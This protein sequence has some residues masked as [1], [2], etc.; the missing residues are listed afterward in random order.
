MKKLIHTF[1]ILAYKESPFLEECILSVLNQTVIDNVVIATSTPN[2]YIKTLARKYNLEIIVNYNG[3]EG[4]GSDFDFARKCVNSALITIA[5]QDDFYEKT[6][7]EEVLNTFKK[8]KDAQI[9]FSNY[10]EIRNG[11]KIYSNLNLKI[12]CLLV[13]CLQFRLLNSVRFF[14]KMSICFGNGICCPAVTYVNS[15]IKYDLLFDS[16]MQSNVDWYAW[17]KL[18]KEKGSFVFVNKRLMGHRVHEGSTTSEIIRNNTR[19]DE[20][21]QILKQFWP[22]FLAKVINGLYKNSEKGNSL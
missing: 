7:L 19:S 14:K 1:V 18:Y 8:N 6:Y 13:Y 11:K 17:G 21:L 9:L 4:I 5:H 20:D 12:K 16:C 2:Q 3:N 22:G 10:Y 15:N